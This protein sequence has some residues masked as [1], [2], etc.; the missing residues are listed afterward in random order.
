MP[1]D[2]NCVEDSNLPDATSNSWFCATNPLDLVLHQLNVSAG[3]TSYRYQLLRAEESN[4]NSTNFW[5][6]AREY[7]SFANVWAKLRQQTMRKHN[8]R[9]LGS[10]SQNGYGPVAVI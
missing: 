8:S 2:F 9:A 6:G 4:N 10:L 1:H 7:R 5:W 3:T